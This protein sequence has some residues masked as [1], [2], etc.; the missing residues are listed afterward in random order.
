MITAELRSESPPNRGLIV[1]DL[2]LNEV[3]PL[4]KKKIIKT[5]IKHSLDKY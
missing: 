3:N 4:I 1:G 5:N 2:H